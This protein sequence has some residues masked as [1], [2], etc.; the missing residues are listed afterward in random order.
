[1]DRKTWVGYVP[2]YHGND[3][4]KPSGGIKGRHRKVKRKCLIGGYPAETK[5]GDYEKRKKVRARGGNTKIKLLKA[6]YANVLI[7]K[8]KQARK[9]KILRVL[10]NPSNRDYDRKGIIT[11]GAIIETELGLA[12]VTSRPGQEGVINALLTES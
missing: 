7:P 12:V 1:M 4:K 11:K 8:K 2:L 5:L 9:V 6:Q 3:N 10:R